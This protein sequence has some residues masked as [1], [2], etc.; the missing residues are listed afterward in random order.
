[1]KSTAQNYAH[2]AVNLKKVEI[3]ELNDLLPFTVTLMSCSVCFVTFITAMR[4]KIC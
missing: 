4:Q 3:T 2:H 1:M